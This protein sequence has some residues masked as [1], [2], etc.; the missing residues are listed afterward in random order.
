VEQREGQRI[1]FASVEGT[2]G[3]SGE[4]VGMQAL[5][6]GA[7][8]N[9]WEN[10][11]VKVYGCLEPSFNL[12]TSHNS[13][14]PASY[15]MFA[16]RI[17]LDHAVSYVERIPDSSDHEH[18]LGF[19]SQRLVRRQL[20]FHDERGL[21]QPATAGAAARVRVRPRPGVFRSLH[22]AGGGRLEHQGRAV[23]LGAGHRSAASAE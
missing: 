6:G 4:S 3:P 8:G 20:P 7:H 21:L 17:E 9:A 1:G 14:S 18:R 10:G 15:D 12:G 16:N 22:P 5:F 11:R 2:R 13:N 19:P 23:H